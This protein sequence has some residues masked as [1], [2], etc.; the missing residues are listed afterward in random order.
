MHAALPCED[1]NAERRKREGEREMEIELEK[2]RDRDMDRKKA[3]NEVF[4]IFL[5]GLREYVFRLHARLEPIQSVLCP[6]PPSW[7]PHMVQNP[8]FS[9]SIF[10]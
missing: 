8:T 9:G 10:G 4:R 6:Y 7:V 3:D 5:G 1:R 2:E